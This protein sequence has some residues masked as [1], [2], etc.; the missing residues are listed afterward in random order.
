MRPKVIEI[1]G[2]MEDMASASFHC[3]IKARTKPVTKA[4]KKLVAKGTFSDIPRWKRSKSTKLKTKERQ[5]A[6]EV[7]TCV[8]LDPGSDLT[9]TNIIE[10]G[11]I[12]AENRGEVLFAEAPGADFRSVR[13]NT[14]E[15]HVRYEHA[16][17]CEEN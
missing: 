10:K 1:M 17:T 12:L 14:H 8:C 5:D 4:A 16:N 15:D 11:D 13:P 2:M 3:L 6:R 7:P 9:R